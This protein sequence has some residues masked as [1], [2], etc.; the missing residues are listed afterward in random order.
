M[1]NSDLI[2]VNHGFHGDL[3]VMNDDSWDIYYAL[4]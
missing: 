2:V 1:V 4:W 3:L